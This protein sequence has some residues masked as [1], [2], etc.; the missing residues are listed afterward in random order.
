MK[1]RLFL[2][3]MVGS[4]SSCGGR[5]GVDL[6]FAPPDA[7]VDDASERD[8]VGESEA[9]ELFDCGDDETIAPPKLE[10]TG[11]YSKWATKTLAPG[12]REFA[13][14]TALWSDGADKHRWVYLP[15]G[16]VIDASNRTE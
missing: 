5:E 15:R 7:A 8:A 16:T 4:L 14:S 2:L 11:L 1:Q 10:C 6:E 9:A 3:V 13:P 12:V